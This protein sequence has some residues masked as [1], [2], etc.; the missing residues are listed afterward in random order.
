MWIAVTR[1]VSPALGECELTHLP[2]CRIDIARARQ[3][4]RAYQDQ[5]IRLGCQ[6]RCLPA[7]PGLPDSVFV[8]DTCVVLDEVAIVTNPGAASRRRETGPVAEVLKEY[9]ELR[10]IQPPGTIDGGDVLVHGKA[11]YVGLS[12][13][14]NIEA[15]AQLRTLLRRHGY[16][17]HPVALRDC[18][19]L[20]S[21][22]SLVAEDTLLLNPCWVESAGFA[23]TS[24]I[25][26][27]SSELFGA[28]AL[29]VGDVVLHPAAYPRTRERLERAAIEV[30]PVDLSELAKAEGGVSCC[31][32]IFR[33]DRTAGLPTIAP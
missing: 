26:V 29:L 24:V 19:H 32:V 33:Q 5:L 18:L 20:K 11:L 28:N 31:S 7:D 16:T 3:Q 1:D 14:T 13:R 25:E 27:H 6:I 22:V 12:T 23:D 17:V 4:H 2:R 10:S 9:R 15:V 30:L 21:A 8:E